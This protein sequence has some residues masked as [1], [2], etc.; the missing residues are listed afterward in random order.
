MGEASGVDAPPEE[1]LTVRELNER[2]E[3]HI[4]GALEDLC[5]RGEVSDLA[6]RDSAVYFDLVGDGAAVNC[7]LWRSRYDELDAGLE[8]GTEVVLEGEVSY[9]VD[10]GRVNLRPWAVSVVGEGEGAEAL[11]ELRAELEDRGWFDDAHKREPPEF[12]GRVGV[13]TSAH[14]DARHDVRQAIHDRDPGVD[15]VLAHAAVQGEDAPTELADAVHRLD[16]HEDVDVVVVG[17]GGGS[18]TDLAAFDTEAVA[19][20][21]FTAETPVVAAVGHREDR[22]VAG[23]VADAEAI[24]P[25]DA[26]EFVADRAA[27][28]ERIDDLADRLERAYAGF[29]DRGVD[30][31]DRRLAAAGERHAERH[32]AD[33]QSRLEAAGRRHAERG[34]ADLRN[35]LAAAGRSLEQRRALRAQERRT[36]RYRAAAVALAVLLAVALAFIIA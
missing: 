7:F 14:G 29:V 2:V 21:I 23:D 18:D 24:T 34:V 4:D 5:C 36:R 8:D 9:Y 17:R 10:R 33:L 26:G 20:A 32:V 27:T 1:V 31:L 11:R 13:V 3:A 12:P 30:D 35:R 6:V 19:E 25:T 16:R 22:T 15:L 28:R